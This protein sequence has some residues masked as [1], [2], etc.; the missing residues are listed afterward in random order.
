MSRAEP[1][2]GAGHTLRTVVDVVDEVVVEV[3]VVWQSQAP[4]A[5][6]HRPGHVESPAGAVPSHAS[7][8]IGSRTPS[9]QTDRRAVNEVTNFPV[10]V[11]AF[12]FAAKV[13]HA[14]AAIVPFSCALRVSPHPVSFALMRVSL[15]FAFTRACEERQPLTNGVPWS[16]I[17]RA[18]SGRPSVCM[19]IGA[20]PGA[21]RNRPPGHAGSAG[22][23]LVST[24]S[25]ADR[26]TAVATRARQASARIGWAL[27]NSGGTSAATT[28][29]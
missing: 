23:A 1:F 20:S 17:V 26:K 15:F 4:N 27:G 21:S 3:L 29:S 13:S 10:V 5:L 16:P 22:F 24:A 11:F 18:A 25:S 6:P 8:L 2:A 19:T 12:S 28:F 14:G 7:P 9:P